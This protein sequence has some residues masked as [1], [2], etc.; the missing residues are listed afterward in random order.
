MIGEAARRISAPFRQGHA[1]IPWP[2]IV[3]MRHKIV[4]DYMEVET[5]VLWSVVSIDLPTLIEQ[6][7]VLVPPET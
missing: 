6:L 4:H 5:D 1:H 3:G 7:E 2:E